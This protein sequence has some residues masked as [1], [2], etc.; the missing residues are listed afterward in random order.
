MATPSNN[1][2]S[3]ARI[4]GRTSHGS[5]DELIVKVVVPFFK[6]L[7]YVD[8]QIAIKFPVKAYR[9]GRVGRKAEAD[10]VLFAGSKRTL[11]DSLVVIEVKSDSE[12]TPEEQAR[13]YSANLFVPFYL[14]WCGCEFDVYQLHAFTPPRLVGSFDLERMSEDLFA[15]VKA[16]LSADSIQ[17]Y[18]RTHEIKT[19]DVQDEL[20]RAEAEYVQKYIEQL[21]YFR[22]LDLARPLDV[23]RAFVPVHIRILE[24]GA[25]DV[26]SVHDAVEQGAYP[27]DL[28]KEFGTPS[29]P[30]LLPAE[31]P[32]VKTMA[33]I[34]DPGSGKTTLLRHFC[35]EICQSATTRIPFFV[36][37][38]QLVAEGIGI[39]R[40]MRS[41]LVQCCSE[42]FADTILATALK[43][44]RA[45]LCLDGLDELDIEE[46]TAA[47]HTLRK[48]AAELVELRATHPDNLIVFTCRRESWP[49]CRS[50][51][52]FPSHD[53]EVLPL[54]PR[55]VRAFVNAWFG[56][57][58]SADSVAL[59]ADFRRNGWP[60][61]STNPLLLGLTCIVFERR[62]RVPERRYLLYQRCLEVLLEE[63]DAT[64][65]ISRSSP[66]P[67]VTPE[68][69]LDLLEDV[70]LH[71]HKQHRACFS[72]QEVIKQLSS[73]LPSTGLSEADGPAAFD[74]LATQHGLLR[75]WSIE[76]LWAFP[77]LCFQEYLAARALRNDANAVSYL[78]SKKDD[79]HWREVVTLYAQVGD[80]SGLVGGLL[81]L[82]E[83]IL[84][85][86]LFLAVTCIRHGTK[87]HQQA[88][89]PE[90][91]SRLCSLAQGQNRHLVAK[92]VDALYR[93]STPETLQC[94]R[95]LA[96]DP[97]GALV[98]SSYAARYLIALYGP[99]AANELIGQYVAG[100]VAYDH[101]L[102]GLDLLPLEI[103][104]KDLEY[105][106]TTSDYPTKEQL[107]HD[108]YTHHR[109]GAAVKAL[110][111]LGEARALPILK[112]LLRSQ[113]LD[114]FVRGWYIPRAIASI[115]D[116]TVPDEL[117]AILHDESLLVDS[118]V[119]AASG[120]GMEEPSAKAYL[121][122]LVAD[123]NADHYDRR[124]AALA[125]LEFELRDEDIQPLESLL[126]DQRL[127]IF[128]GGPACAAEAI[129]RI[130]TPGAREALSRALAMW[131]QSKNEGAQNIL[132]HIEMSSAH[133][134]A[135]SS[136]ETALF[137]SKYEGVWEKPGLLVAFFEQYPSQAESLFL[138][139]LDSYGEEVLYGRTKAWG[140]AIAM[141]TLPP[142]PALI[143]SLIKLAL[144]VRSGNEGTWGILSQIWERRDLPPEVRKLF[145]LSPPA[146][147]SD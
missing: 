103:A 14:A 134:G 53:Y 5:E 8:D 13:F 129:A 21:R 113:C 16:I 121:I 4:L 83:N 69:M 136:L 116:D 68:H 56:T 122:Q 82:P 36:P 11:D 140:I 20:R 32:R 75:S 35:A 101:L 9:P 57:V 10:C 54:S 125:L 1:A 81:A 90:I 138:Q 80:A 27:K 84:H 123:K 111:R 2:S 63:W 48:L 46:P 30:V 106:V 108:P 17:A 72:R 15:R 62:K 29:K 39:R 55:S 45:V 51:I 18:C 104:L 37:V 105:V 139:E 50:S 31:L 87:L 127:G 12:S 131:R 73:A 114:P 23:L 93:L 58:G 41:H 107:G 115:P 98:P 74:A 141:L 26:D 76:A 79:P 143:A 99:A 86:N 126:F 85:T 145:Y 65:R 52:A 34:G 147:S 124:D 28:E 59:L 61:F 92:A 6:L 146:S 100:K 25:I 96:R 70:A 95:Q 137:Q 91:C 119:N 60:E 94:L 43:E 42:P 88:L 112:R 47:R 66:L 120:L 71:F 44:G 40:A 67:E 144:R 19:F 7:R 3:Q 49:T 33:L 118:R 97:E 109:R 24:S 78:L 117:R 64:R 135:D 110:A 132:G 130:G 22:L 128:W 133:A 102:D 77:H 142:R 89:R 38:R